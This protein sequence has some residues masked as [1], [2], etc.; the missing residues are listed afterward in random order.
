M[1]SF[2]ATG[3]CNLIN[4]KIMTMKLNI[5]KIDTEKVLTIL[6]RVK[7]HLSVKEYD[8]LHAVVSTLAKV[9]GMLE[10]QSTS[11]KRLR[12]LFF[13][14]K[15]E[16]TKKVIREIKDQPKN[17]NKKPSKGHGK[18]GVDAYAGASTLTIEHATMT[19]GDPC[20]AC[21]R[22]KV[23]THQPQKV[24]R[25]NGQSPIGGTIIEIERLRCRICG[26]IFKDS[27]VNIDI[28]NQKYD[29]S[30][31]AMMA[32]LKYGTGLPFNRL[33]QLQAS[34]DIPLPSSTQWSYIL[35][36]LP[37]VEPI[38]K[39]LVGLAAN[40]QVVHNDDTGM[41][42]L[43]LM[44]QNAK[45]MEAGEKERTGIFTTG[46]VSILEDK[47][48]ALF[49]TG[50]R[51][52]GEN[53]EE[54]LKRRTTLDDPIQMCDGL[55]RNIP[56]DEAINTIVGNCMAHGRRKFVELVE[57]FPDEVQ[58]VLLK[59]REVYAIE[60]EAKEQRLSPQARLALHQKKSKSVMEKLFEWLQ[61]QLDQKQVEPN[62]GLGKAIKYMLK[63]QE[64]LTLFL[65]VAG[66]PLDNNL[67]ERALKISILHRKNAFFYKTENGAR[68]GDTYMSLIATCKLQKIN[69][70]TYLTAILQNKEIASK[71]PMEWLP[72]NF[73]N[74]LSALEKQKNCG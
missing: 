61:E 17:K 30:A 45:T 42:V 67:C 48:V 49:L 28:D 43:A 18:N 34:M 56:K 21:E 41:K 12:D 32:L 13:G 71:Q 16:K 72:W 54:L 63:R 4:H 55:D 20:P 25:L 23:Y 66:A 3:V 44:A 33:D 40:G 14:S 26:K 69:P 65:R 6:E 31:V 70:F 5:I 64:R 15:C 22:G 19:S 59:I 27:S 35:Q 74:A 46:I 38:F 53:L 39:A 11:L 57:S 36:Y 8:L 47:R 73:N 7:P 2:S 52:A 60:K 37:H 68:A 50:A 1:N 62:S 51:H 9:V 24:V 29:A 10:K 58:H